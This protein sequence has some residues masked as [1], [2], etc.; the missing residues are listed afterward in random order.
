LA[1]AAAGQRAS[2]SIAETGT[3]TAAMKI[4]VS[5]QDIVHIGSSDVFILTPP[6]T[7]TLRASLVLVLIWIK[8]SSRYSPVP[9]SPV[10]WASSPEIS[11]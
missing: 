8:P 2:S 4:A 3:T 10:A 9:P 6:L 5:T 1:C 11:A 7:K